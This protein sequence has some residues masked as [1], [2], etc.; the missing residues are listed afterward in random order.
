MEEVDEIYLPDLEW[1]IKQLKMSGNS[2]GFPD[3]YF[4]Q[5]ENE[6]G[7]FY[8]FVNVFLTDWFVMAIILSVD[9]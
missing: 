6:V 4:E 5:W 3:V 2:T 7:T 9:Q 1:S 8:S